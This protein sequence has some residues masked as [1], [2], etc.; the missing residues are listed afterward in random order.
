[1]VGLVCLLKLLKLL[2][3]QL[4]SSFLLFDL[5][6]LFFYGFFVVLELFFHPFDRLIDRAALAA[7]QLTNEHIS[8][9]F[10]VIEFLRVF[11]MRAFEVVIILTQI[12]IL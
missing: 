12:L 2:Y 1:M 10:E 8:F 7:A 11:V 9:L 5:F 3:L 6:L 4:Q